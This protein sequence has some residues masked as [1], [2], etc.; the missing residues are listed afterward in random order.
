MV[1]GIQWPCKYCV[2]YANMLVDCRVLV[3]IASLT[4]DD[5]AGVG[6]MVA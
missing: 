2:F 5:A 3:S 6:W 1:L 4:M